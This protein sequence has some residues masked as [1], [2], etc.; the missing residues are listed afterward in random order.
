MKNILKI[1]QKYS[2]SIKQKMIEYKL[3]PEKLTKRNANGWSSDKQK[4]HVQGR[5][6]RNKFKL[7]QKIAMCEKCILLKIIRRL[8]M[9]LNLHRIKRFENNSRKADGEE[10]N[11]I[12]IFVGL[13][14]FRK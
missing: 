7:L 8:C 9:L 4:I 13:I 3:S 10:K 1:G 11:E 12:K 5:K 6:Y 2:V 14:L